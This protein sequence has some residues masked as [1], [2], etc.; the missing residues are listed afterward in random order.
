MTLQEQ[1]T[2]EVQA[3]LSQHGLDGWRFGKAALGDP[4]FVADLERGRCP[5][6]NTIE[7]VRGYMDSVAAGSQQRRADA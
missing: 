5:N 4:N 1:F 6:L 7:K 2:A 3:F